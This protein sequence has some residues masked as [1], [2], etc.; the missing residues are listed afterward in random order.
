MQCW[1]GAS[2]ARRDA[3]RRRARARHATEPNSR[4]AA[5]VA[6]RTFLFAS[7]HVVTRKSQDT[8]TTSRT[9]TRRATDS[10][11]PA[12]QRSYTLVQRKR[13]PMPIGRSDRNMSLSIILQYLY[14]LINTVYP[15][16]PRCCVCPMHE[17]TRMPEH[18]AQTL[19]FTCHAAATC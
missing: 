11:G 1:C 19:E 18:C 17:P 6:A 16:L 3:R 7:S 9:R 15:P 2:G 10:T 13:D 5:R 4:V 8:C 14:Y 12:V